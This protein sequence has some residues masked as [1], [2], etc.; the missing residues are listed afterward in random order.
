MEW[1]L[2]WPLWI[3]IRFK[4]FTQLPQEQ[5]ETDTETINFLAQLFMLGRNSQ[6]GLFSELIELW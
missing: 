2:L 6:E 3:L 4:D 1:N 5:K